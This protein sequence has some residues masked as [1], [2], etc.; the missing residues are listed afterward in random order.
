MSYA[1]ERLEEMIWGISMLT[2]IPLM[3]I[4]TYTQKGELHL[5]KGVTSMLM[6][7]RGEQQY[8]VRMKGISKNAI[9]NVAEQYGGYVQLYEH[10]FKS[11]E[12]Y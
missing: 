12:L 6:N 3:G 8:H 11:S 10:L 2:L 5:G 9:T 7:S 1:G 4:V